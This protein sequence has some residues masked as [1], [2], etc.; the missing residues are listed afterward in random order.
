MENV[1]EVG[2]AK[3]IG[4]SNFRP[5]ELK[6]VLDIARIKPAVNQVAFH[7]Y[8][9]EHNKALLSLASQHGVV[10]A[11]FSGLT[12]ITQMPGGPLDPVLNKIA[13]RLGPDTTPAQVIFAWIHNKGVVIVTTS[14]KKERLHEYLD[15]PKLGP[16][17]EAEIEEI[18]EAG[19]KGGLPD[20]EP[21]WKPLT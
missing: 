19:I 15:F 4:V 17:T 1:K 3:S 11:S 9:W 16:L 7:P 14:S 18:E 5:F 8:N 6:K 2:L 10:V 12:P 13:K 21:P 20:A